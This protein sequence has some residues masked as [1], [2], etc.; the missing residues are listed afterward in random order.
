MAMAAERSPDSAI[1]CNR[2]LRAVTK[3]IS[4]MAKTPLSKVSAI[5]MAI[6]KQDLLQTKNWFSL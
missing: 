6:S 4:D 5:S 1:R 2:L 3:A